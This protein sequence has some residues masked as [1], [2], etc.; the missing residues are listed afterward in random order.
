MYQYVTTIW[1]KHFNQES[2]LSCCLAVRRLGSQHQICLKIFHLII[3]AINYLSVNK[4]SK[5][6]R[7]IFFYIFYRPL[8]LKES[9]TVY[10]G[11]G[12]PALTVFLSLD[13][14]C[15]YVIKGNKYKFLKLVIHCY[16]DYYYEDK[17]W[18]DS[19]K[20]YFYLVQLTCIYIFCC[21]FKN[22]VELWYRKHQ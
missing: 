14:F 11:Y 10:D 5:Y 16:E 7:L 22:T 8:P 17:Y 20:Y 19:F 9:N 21:Y 12:H 4:K 15:K 13:K 3:L 1:N 6:L 2:C 18:F